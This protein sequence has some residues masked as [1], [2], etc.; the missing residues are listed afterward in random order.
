MWPEMSSCCFDALVREKVYDSLLL[1]PDQQRVESEHLIQR[2]LRQLL[3]ARTPNSLL[4]ALG[5][6]FFWQTQ[7]HKGV[8]QKQTIIIIRDHKRHQTPGRG[9]LQG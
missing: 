6:K 7:S 8:G 2:L 3:R 9:A 5:L 1:M 4:T